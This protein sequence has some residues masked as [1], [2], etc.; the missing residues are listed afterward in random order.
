ME[1]PRGP[2]TQVNLSWIARDE[3]AENLGM[4]PY[5]LQLRTV[6]IW[7]RNGSRTNSR[8]S[9]GLRD[10]EKSRSFSVGKAMEASSIPEGV[11]KGGEA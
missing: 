3:L 8:Q 6:L 5:H 11:R 7:A 9:V 4:D 1:G 10:T 2:G